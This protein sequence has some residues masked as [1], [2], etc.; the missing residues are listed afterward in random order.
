MMIVDPHNVMRGLKNWSSKTECHNVTNDALKKYGNFL[1]SND[2]YG[3]QKCAT[4]KQTIENIKML[5]TRHLLELHCGHF[6]V[7]SNG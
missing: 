6:N 1:L 5:Q 7:G 4:F 2:F 3:W